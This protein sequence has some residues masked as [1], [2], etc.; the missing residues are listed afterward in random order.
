MVNWA[1]A[2]LAVITGSSLPGSAMIVAAPVTVR[3]CDIASQVAAL[4]GASQAGSEP[5]FSAST[6]RIGCSIVKFPSQSAV[7]GLPADGVI[8]NRIGTELPPEFKSAVSAVFTELGKLSNTKSLYPI[9]L[10]GKKAV[11]TKSGLAWLP[12]TLGPVLPVPP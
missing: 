4:P 12:S 3:L 10:F 11:P 6:V 2:P 5:V 8:A 7:T 9:W 1:A